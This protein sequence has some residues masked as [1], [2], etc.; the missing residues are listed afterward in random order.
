M[1][2]LQR[3]VLL[4]DARTTAPDVIQTLHT[5]HPRIPTVGLGGE[6]GQE[7]VLLGREYPPTALAGLGKVLNALLPE[8]P[9][10]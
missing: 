6:N 4:Y 7:L 10:A 3:G 5:L 9:E 8:E 2:S 1:T